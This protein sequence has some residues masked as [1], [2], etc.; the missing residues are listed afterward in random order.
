VNFVGT[1]FNDYKSF[2]NFLMEENPGK[3][4]FFFECLKGPVFFAIFTFE[5]TGK[6]P[7]RSERW[8]LEALLSRLWVQKDS[9]RVLSTFC[10]PKDRF[11]LLY[12]CHRNATFRN[13]Q[14]FGNLPIFVTKLG[15]FISQ[16]FVPKRVGSFVYF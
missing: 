11:V 7:F 9:F 4:R 10:W 3:D 8:M 6:H 1:I 14:F 16:D 2:R 15:V 5:S 12:Q 13:F